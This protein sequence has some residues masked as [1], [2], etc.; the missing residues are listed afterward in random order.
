[1]RKHWFNVMQPAVRIKINIGSLCLVCLTLHGT[2]QPGENGF[3][4][5]L[6]IRE[7]D[8]RFFSREVD[9]YR[10]N[11]PLHGMN[12]LDNNMWSVW[13]ALGGLRSMVINIHSKP[14]LDMFLEMP[15]TSLHE[16]IQNVSTTQLDYRD[17][18]VFWILKL[19]SLAAVIM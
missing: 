12:K 4:D 18:V 2:N 10:T 16:H 15:H 14:S 8:S 11:K 17:P 9:I 13:T 1:M 7:L 6:W 3:Q 19:C 5:V